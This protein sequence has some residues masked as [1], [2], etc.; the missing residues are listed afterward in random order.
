[1]HMTIVIL[2]LLNISFFLMHELDACH[3]GEWKMFKFLRRF[4]EK[5]QYQIF[6]WFHLPLC[7]FLLYYFGTV[8]SSSNFWLWVVVNILVLL[9]L[10]VHVV[11]RK[12]KSNVFT[13]LS[14]LLLIAGSALTSALNLMFFAYY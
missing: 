1:M 9:H 3:K 4:Q 2:T 6:L 13:S 14:S 10:I 7:A 12:W 5:T 8:L 11:A